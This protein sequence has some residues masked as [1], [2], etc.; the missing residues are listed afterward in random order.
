MRVLDGTFSIYSVVQLIKLFI[1]RLVKLRTVPTF[2][3]RFDLLEFSVMNSTP[4]GMFMEFGVAEGFSAE[5]IAS[6]IPTKTLYGFDSFEGL[7]ED[8]GAT[9]KGTFARGEYGIPQV[10]D[11]IELIVGWF[12]D[13]LEQFLEDH[14]EKASFIHCDADLYSS[15]KH[16][17]STLTLYN[18]LE[19]GTIIQFDEFF[20]M[21]KGLKSEYNAFIEI[22]EDYRIKFEYIGYSFN[23]FSVR[24]LEIGGAAQ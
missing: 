4:G 18:R 19:R 3:R 17:L 13:T 11:N 7:P 6:L 23:K 16:V 2:K 5:Y 15:T 8:L 14:P 1:F 12:E 24:I 22:V 9:V 10:S 20:T 21:Q